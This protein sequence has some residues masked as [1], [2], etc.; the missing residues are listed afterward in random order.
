VY[1]GYLTAVLGFSWGCVQTGLTP[2]ADPVIESVQ[3]TETFV[4]VSNPKVDVLWVVDN[5]GS[6]A[7]EQAALAASFEAFVEAMDDASLGYQLG[8]VTTEVDAERAGELRGNPWIITSESADASQ[9]FAEAISVGTDGAGAEAGLSAMMLALSEPLISSV[10]RGF[11][12]S[13]A[14]LH[15]IAVSDDDDDSE[16]SSA[17]PVSD[18]VGEAL[19]FLEDEAAATGLPAFFSAVVCDDVGGCACQGGAIYGERYID[20][21]AATGGVVSGICDGDLA[22]VVGALGA[23]SITYPDT[24][25]LQ[26]APA[27]GD[28]VIDVDGERVSDGWVLTDDP[29]VVFDEPPAPGALIQVTYELTW[30]ESAE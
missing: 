16:A 8:V 5:T 26:S 23:L 14:A 4:Q 17:H 11:R 18:P 29:A 24:F 20:V 25:P 21:A 12:R 15:V 19:A 9:A 22:A 2:D 28:V 27:D 30:L 13:D 1:L 7:E 10:N 3:I 6:M